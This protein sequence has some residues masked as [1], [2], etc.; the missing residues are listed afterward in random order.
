MKGFTLLLLCWASI[1]NAQKDSTYIS[2][3]AGSWCCGGDPSPAGVMI[4]HVH[5][6]G[7]WMVS[8]RYMHMQMEGIVSGQS[9]ITISDVLA[10]YT[11]APLEMQMD[12]HMGMLM[13]GL[14]DKLTLMGMFNYSSNWMKMKMTMGQHVHTHNMAAKGIG[15]TRLS[16]LYALKTTE[17]Q[18]LLISTGINLPTG[19]INLKGAANAMMYPRQRMPY[20]MQT[21]SGSFE[22]PATINYAQINGKWY[23]S[24]QVNALIRLGRNVLYYRYGNEWSLQSWVARKWQ[25]GWSSSLRAEFT[26]Q[27]RLVGNDASLN[28]TFEPAANSANYGFQRLIG[29]FGVV[30]EPE[31]KWLEQLR[32]AIEGG[33]P[34]YQKY[35]GIQMPL[36]QTL[37]FS[38]NY[39][40]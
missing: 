15:D 24:A 11:A 9:P 26:Q 35:Q 30:Y 28:P 25:H 1:L 27:F 4:S 2:C 13:Y 19:K 12:M 7:E 33:Y 17:T 3:H 22:L 21:S 38:I 32:L 16:V 37:L 29:F 20:M 23:Y 40:F 34:V 14:T 36:T 6:K 18:Q 39:N 10:T 8:Y 31:G 5:A